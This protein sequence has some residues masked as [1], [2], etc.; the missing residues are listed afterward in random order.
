[1]IKVGRH[2][3][4]LL[5]DV[6]HGL[7][8][9]HIHLVGHIVGERDESHRRHARILFVEIDHRPRDSLGRS[10]EEETQVAE[11]RPVRH[12]VGN[13]LGTS[14]AD[15][16]L[17]VDVPFVGAGTIV[18][19]Y[20]RNIEFLYVQIGI[21]KRVHGLGEGRGHFYG[22]VVIGLGNAPADGIIPRA[23]LQQG[24]HA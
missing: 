7:G 10:I 22:R 8:H 11:D 23:R 3:T 16:L 2:R 13:P 17:G 14:V 21:G 19:P 1:M 5:G 18:V 12:R 9:A 6:E 20:G 4:Y 15:D 24:G